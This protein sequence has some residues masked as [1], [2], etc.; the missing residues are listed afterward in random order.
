MSMKKVCFIVPFL[1]KSGPINVVKDIISNIDRGK[2]DVFI[3]SL[4]PVRKQYTK[5]AI[6]DLFKQ[7][8]VKLFYIGASNMDFFIRKKSIIKRIQSIINNHGIDVIHSHGHFPVVIA[9]NLINVRKVVTIHNVASSD[10][11]L[12]HG[13]F[14]GKLM[15]FQ[16]KRNL[17]YF[18][19]C[20]TISK[21]VDNHYKIPNGNKT[22]IYNGIDVNNF[23]VNLE[24][25]SKLRSELNIPKN[26]NVYI[27]SGR[28]SKRKNTSLIISAFKK[29]FQNNNNNFLL[30]AGTG[31]EKN[32]CI[33]MSQNSNNII[34]LGYVIGIEKYLQASDFLISSSLSEGMPLGILEGISCGLYPI[35]SNIPQHIEIL[36][37][38][39]LKCATFA[40]HSTDELEKIF[41]TIKKIV[42]NKNQI[43]QKLSDVFSAKTMANRYC[44]IYLRKD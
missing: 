34:F 8:N 43:S 24:N 17:H 12:G 31:E 2:I 37:K 35:L 5:R 25:I 6:D 7:L 19:D 40:P 11:V 28:L 42:I 22:K 16:F 20:I 21:E 27:V 33:E 32:N 26:A 4:M 1:I 3:I 41:K 10:Y 14:I 44:E 13:I 29:V 39:E 15:A 30:I 38:I 36:N 9:K 18:D 23:C